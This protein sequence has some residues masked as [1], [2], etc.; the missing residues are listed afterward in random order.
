MIEFCE[1][2]LMTSKNEWH[3]SLPM[4]EEETSYCWMA[5]LGLKDAY[6]L[7]G[8]TAESIFDLS[9]MANSMSLSASQIDSPVHLEFLPNS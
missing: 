8:Q 2:L 4:R 7:L 3:A 9:M 6:Y 1:V 5:V